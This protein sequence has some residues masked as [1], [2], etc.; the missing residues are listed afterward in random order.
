VEFEDPRGDAQP[1]RARKHWREDSDERA[2]FVVLPRPPDDPGPDGYE[3]DNDV[4]AGGG[5]P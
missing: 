5:V 2:G 1:S 4:A 3:Y